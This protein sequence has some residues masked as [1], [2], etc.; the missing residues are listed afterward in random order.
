MKKL[1]YLAFFVLAFSVKGFADDKNKVVK[2][3][4]AVT[5]FAE[6]QFFSRYQSA[7][8][9][10]W[11]VTDRF[12]KASFTMGGKKMSA[13]F[14]ATGNYIATTQYISEDKLPAITK[15]RLK[16]VY[17][18]Y[19]VKEVIRYEMD[20]HEEAQLYQLTGQRYY[21]NLYFANL[22]NGTES[23]IVKISPDGQITYLSSL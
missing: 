15:N 17:K 23:I 3:E 6:N 1:I 8:S 18:G 4:T 10:N 12:Q 9:V 5:Y 13:F 19:E 22:S 2:A 16:K 20:G 11:I 21:D 14:D 7:K